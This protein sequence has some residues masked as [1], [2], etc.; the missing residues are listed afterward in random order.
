MSGP[1][2]P[3]DAPPGRPRSRG[4]GAGVAGSTVVVAVQT[5]RAQVILWLLVGSLICLNF[6][7]SVTAPLELLPWSVT[8]FFGG[9]QN[10]SLLTGTATTIALLTGLLM[11]GCMLAARHR[12]DPAERG[13]RLLAW[14]ALFVFADET[15]SLHQ[16][17]ATA[18]RERFHVTGVA[19]YTWALVYLPVL[20]AV[21][22]VLLRDVRHF[23]VPVRRRLFPGGALYVVGVVGLEPFLSRLAEERGVGSLSFRLMLALADSCAVVGLV[24]VFSAALVAA[25]RLADGFTLVLRPGGRAP[26]RTAGSPRLPGES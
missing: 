22:A 13:W 21:L 12:G 14:V 2:W 1:P 5:G 9:N 26:D 6:L 7:V 20:V 16:S 8:R 3:Q 23:P 18:V 17:L 4:R 15:T 11:S 10:D 24:L 19:R 25:G